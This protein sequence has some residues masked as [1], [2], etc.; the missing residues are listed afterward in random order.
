MFS[1]LFN[2][3]KE[4]MEIVKCKNVKT[5]TYSAGNA[6]YD[7]YVPNDFPLT[8]LYPG[9][10]LVIKSGIKCNIPVGKVLVAFDKSGVSTTQHIGVIAPVVDECY[11]GEIS[12]CIQHFG[13]LMTMIHPGQKLIQF[14]LLDYSLPELKVVKYIN[15]V[16]NRG[17]NGFGSTGLF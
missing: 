12:L 6:G 16:T 2:S 11:T 13:Q 8:Y 7:F 10:T 14:I 9:Q 3:V 17:D 5:P 4:T 1:S 15:K